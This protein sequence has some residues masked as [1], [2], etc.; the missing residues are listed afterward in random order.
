MD[1]LQKQE[2]EM[3]VKR[4]RASRTEPRDAISV[5]LPHAKTIHS[6]QFKKPQ[7]NF[8][9]NQIAILSALKPACLNLNKNTLQMLTAKCHFF[10]RH[11]ETILFTPAIIIIYL[12]TE[13]IIL[14]ISFFSNITEYL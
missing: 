7:F 2:V 10:S 6:K 4:R 14:K 8:D 12:K 5:H 9:W 1:I 13:Y 3:D 11:T